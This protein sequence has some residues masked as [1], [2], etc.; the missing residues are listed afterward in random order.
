[1]AGLGYQFDA[2]T[3]WATSDPDQGRCRT[4]AAA[5]GPDLAQSLS[6]GAQGI[7]PCDFLYVDTI[8]LTRIYEAADAFGS[9]G[10]VPRRPPVV[11]PVVL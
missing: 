2:T 5:G 8:D 4:G 7:L 11:R 6:A 10:R 3:M 1:L 9:P